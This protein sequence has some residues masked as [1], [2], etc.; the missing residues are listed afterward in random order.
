MVSYSVVTPLN[1]PCSVCSSFPPLE[2]LATTDLFLVSIV[3]SLSGHPIVGIIEYVAFSYW[4][5]SLRNVHFSFL[6][7]FSGLD[8]SFL[9]SAE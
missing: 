2:A 4:N 3:L 1:I 5:L 7:V 8:G 6:H 9:F